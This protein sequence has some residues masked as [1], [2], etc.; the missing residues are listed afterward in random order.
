MA[1]QN[2][3]ASYQFLRNQNPS[4]SLSAAK[5]VLLGHVS[6]AVDGEIVLARYTDG[7]VVKTLV[8]SYYVNGGTKS[9]TI[10]EASDDIKNYVDDKINAL[11]LNT[12][13]GVG[14]VITAITQTDGKVSAVTGTVSASTVA[15]AT[16]TTRITSA[17][18]NVQ[19]AIDTLADAV[20]SSIIGGNVKIVSATTSS[21]NVMEEW[22]LVTTAGQEIP[23][24]SHIKIYKD[25]SLLSVA[26][27]HATGDTKPTYDKSTDT[28]T[29]IPS[30]QQTEANKALCF[31]YE[32]A[33]GSILV[34][35]VNVGS[36]INEAEFA[37][38]VTWDTTANKARGVV[39]STSESGTGSTKLLTVGVNGF[40][41]SGVADLI[42]SKIQG[43]I[44]GSN[45]INISDRSG[46]G[47]TVEAIVP[48]NSATGIEN[49]I[50]ITSDGIVMGTTLDAGTY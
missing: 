10:T 16:A 48:Q 26:L 2:T 50:K 43:T 7:S 39:D 6:S 41:I 21:A 17:N 40:K 44:D 29:D 24:S 30:G 15:H 28:W 19:D 33:D 25:S 36:F 34:E 3:V 35:A 12:V 9:V 37:S 8:G 45:A 1:T 49:P 32:T 42:N 31:A 46:G 5:D 47:V 13:S 4:A 11:D 27:L 22:K 14:K 23:G 18:T 20:G 38:G